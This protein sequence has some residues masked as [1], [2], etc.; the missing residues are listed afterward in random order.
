MAGLEGLEGL[1]G[2][3]R[4]A[5]G[6]IQEGLPHGRGPHLT[7]GGILR[8]NSKCCWA[9]I[10]LVEVHNLQQHIHKEGPQL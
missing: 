5:K 7:Q 10:E 4:M 3:G 6:T 9:R 8:C 2:M 1:T